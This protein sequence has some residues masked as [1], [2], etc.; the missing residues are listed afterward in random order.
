MKNTEREIPTIYAGRSCRRH[1]GLGDGDPFEGGNERRGDVPGE[2]P[3]LRAMMAATV[4]D[5]G[6]R[7][8]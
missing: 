7:R 3:E 4:D 2:S 6:R 8:W 1:L 5:G